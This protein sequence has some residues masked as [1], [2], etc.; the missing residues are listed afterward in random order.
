MLF[1]FKVLHVIEV[2]VEELSV[3]DAIDRVTRADDTDAI[4]KSLQVY[5]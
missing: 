1:L 2:L 5:Y 3:E 4:V